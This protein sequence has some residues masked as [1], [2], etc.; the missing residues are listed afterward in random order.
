MAYTRITALWTGV[1]GLPGYTRL[2]FNGELTSAESALAAGRMRA[3]FE[4]I[5][6]KLAL[7][8]NIS[9]AEAAQQFN[10]L[11]E[12]IGEVAY[13]PPAP[14]T[15]TGTGAFAAPVGV[16]VNWLTDV[17][18]KGPQGARPHVPGAAGR[19]LVR[20]E[21]GPP[22][23]DRD[24]RRRRRQHAGRGLAAAVRAGRGRGAR[25]LRVAHHRRQ[26]PEP[27]GHPEVSE[28]LDEQPYAV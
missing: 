9:F 22:C 26:R 3:F 24:R 11:G 4:A 27:R 28:R 16:V 8:V 5:K 10:T 12:L 17:V 23:C 19:E 7:G 2:R 1:A 25:L 18:F 21:R 13:A 6:P 20:A 14:V 15:S